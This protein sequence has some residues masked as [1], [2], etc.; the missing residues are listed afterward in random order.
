MQ[1]LSAV[2]A[3]DWCFVDSQFEGLESGIISEHYRLFWGFQLFRKIIYL[4]QV[5]ELS[6]SDLTTCW[7]CFELTV[8]VEVGYFH[9][10]FYLP[11]VIGGSDQG[12]ACY[13]YFLYFR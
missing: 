5:S 8:V 7:L 4:Y 2:F 13:H 12:T 6:L 10:L 1:S 11:Q 9:V 3:A